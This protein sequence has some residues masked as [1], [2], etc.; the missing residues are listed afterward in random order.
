MRVLHV[1]DKS[2]MGGGQ[3]IVRNLTQ[4]L[5][6]EGLHVE[7]ACRT[8]GPLV[9]WIRELGAPLHAVPF[10]KNFRPGPARAVARIVR[11]NDLALVHAHGLVA[12]F[13]CT[14]ARRFFG[15]RAP[16]LY[17]QHGFHHHNYG[18]ATIALRKAAERWVCRRADRVIASTVS[19]QR[20]LAEGGY[21]RPE[22]IVLLRNGIPDR[23]PDPDDVARARA[24]IP[25][26]E[27]A[28][29]VGMVARIHLQKGIDVFLRAVERVR[30]VLPAVRFVLVGSGELEAEMKD[31][32]RELRLDDVLTFAGSLPARACYPFF[33]VA[34]MTS[35]WEGLP[36]TL[37]EYMA[38]GRPIV[39]TAFAGIDEIVREDEAEL[40][41]VDDDSAV[42][43][44]IVRVLRDPALARRRADA[45]R[46]H[47]E[48]SYTL[49][50]IA[51]QYAAL[52]REVLA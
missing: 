5:Q 52:Y 30:R 39:A 19:D 17:Q 32:A 10:D 40:V 23:E 3:V 50:A 8:P 4:G 20:L 44:A 11:E 38:I 14:L 24:A 21:A 12:A 27:T 13:Y 37:I 35:R 9:D 25:R 41:P 15:L 42:A 48:E 45:A 31:L 16:L 28:P 2:F 36:N 1:I 33:D 43:D 29:L 46:R 6:Q 26:A 22:R 7:V 51:P 47:Y 34:V 49:E 18:P